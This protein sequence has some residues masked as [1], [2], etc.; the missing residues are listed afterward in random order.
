MVGQVLHVEDGEQ[1]HGALSGQLLLLPELGKAEHAVPHGVADLVVQADL[2]VVL[3]T[4]V[5]KQA[6]VL[7]G[8]GDAGPVDLGSAHAVGVLAIEQD[9]APGGLIHLGEQVEHRGL[10]RA[11]GAD[12][13]GNLCAADGEVELIDS[14]QAA[15]V[16]AQVLALQNGELVHIPLRNDGVAGDGDHLAFLKFLSHSERLL[17]RCRGPISSGAGRRKTPW[18]ARCWWPA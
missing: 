5:G 10:A 1:L 13:A 14:G 4:Q 6:D 3:H 16:D 15:E 11:V 17:S 18:S 9:G 12:K 8:A 7:E 2:H